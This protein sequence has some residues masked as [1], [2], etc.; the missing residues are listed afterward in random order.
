MKPTSSPSVHPSGSRQIIFDRVMASCTALGAVSG[1][2]IVASA[3]EASA[4]IVYS[5]PISLTVPATTAGLYLN[6][7]T[8]ASSALPLAVPGWDLNPYSSTGF[9]FFNPGS[10]ANS[11]GVLTV[12]GVALIPVGTFVDS[13]GIFTSGGFTSQVT[14]NSPNNYIGF[15]FYNESTTA[16][17]YGWAQFLFGATVQNRSFIGYA[18]DDV[19]GAGITIGATGISA[20]PEPSSSMGVLALGAA[21]LLIRSRKAA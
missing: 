5:G 2:G 3:P 16:I 10:P 12:G 7:L 11:H 17:H 8:G 6:V 21:G 20:I 13:S 18:F 19:P 4:A 15:R 1:V 9:S 14:L